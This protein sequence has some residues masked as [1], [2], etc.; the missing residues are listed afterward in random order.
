MTK[1]KFNW[2]LSEWKKTFSNT[3]PFSIAL[4]K[5][6]K[7]WKCRHHKFGF[8]VVFFILS[9]Y[10]HSFF[11]INFFH[12]RCINNTLHVRNKV[13]CTL[14]YFCGVYSASFRPLFSYYF[15]VC[16]FR[17]VGNLWNSKEKRNERQ[18]NY[19]DSYTHVLPNTL[20]HWTLS[21]HQNESWRM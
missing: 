21:H 2:F 10:F 15:G 16:E 9:T 5:E 3:L 6:L 8:V 18:I 4:G 11:P 14:M 19:F 13:K 7:S 12:E 20:E 17:M 1:I